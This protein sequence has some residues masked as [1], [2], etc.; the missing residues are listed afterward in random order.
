MADKNY[1]L[2][3]IDQSNYEEIKL[4]LS[5]SSEDCKSNLLL[6]N[7]HIN[8]KN[9]GEAEKIYELINKNCDDNIKNMAEKNMN[10]FLEK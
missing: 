1:I 8:Y 2:R 9:Y 10:E 5:E 4:L 3:A 7:A 6:M